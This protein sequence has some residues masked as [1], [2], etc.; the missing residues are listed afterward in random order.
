[1]AG[2]GPDALACWLVL[3]SAHV[4]SRPFA[5]T[6]IRARV[7]RA[8]R[9]R[10]FAAPLLA[11]IVIIEERPF[12]T[13]DSAAAV[14]VRLKAVFADQRANPGRLYVDGVAGAGWRKLDV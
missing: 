12:R 14:A 5:V 2:G 4:G 6:T 13:D 11:F 8:A 7:G 9:G 10:R 3:E 1:G